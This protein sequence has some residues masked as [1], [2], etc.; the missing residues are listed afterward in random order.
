[1]VLVKHL[2][3]DLIL[4]QLLIGSLEESGGWLRANQE[5]HLLSD[6]LD[7]EDGAILLVAFR[8]L[9][10]NPAGEGR[11]GGGRSDSIILVS[12]AIG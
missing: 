12:K 1:M 5:S 6:H 9:V 2:P 3:I 8:N 4:S 11:R 10:V 7:S